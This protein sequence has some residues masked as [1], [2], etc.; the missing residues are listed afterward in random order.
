M[1]RLRYALFCFLHFMVY[2]LQPAINDEERKEFL[3]RFHRN[4]TL[5]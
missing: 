5:Y 1:K 2:E 3:E 4:D